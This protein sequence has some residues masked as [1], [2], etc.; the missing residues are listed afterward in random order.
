MTAVAPDDA[1][2]G[3]SARCARSEAASVYLGGECVS[4]CARL[5]ED[6]PGEDADA[7]STRDLGDLR[8][9]DEPPVGHRALLVRRC[10]DC[11]E[12]VVNSCCSEVLDAGSKAGNVGRG[13]RSRNLT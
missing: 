11:D 1:G 3:R 5:C 7:L 9:L 4:A 2:T 12:T 8:V 10:S 13:E 6:V